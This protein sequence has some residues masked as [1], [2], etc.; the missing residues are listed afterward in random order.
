MGKFSATF[1]G[2]GQVIEAAVYVVRG[3]HRSL[4]SYKTAS[5]LKLITIL[6]LVA[7]HMSVD[8]KKAFPKLFGKIGKLKNYQVKLNISK[9]V[10]LVARQHR[11][12][13]FQLESAGERAHTPGAA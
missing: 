10:K 12:T 2:Q 8:A 5:D 9:D 1:C 6:Q 13:P 4:L 3:A 11:R 7:E